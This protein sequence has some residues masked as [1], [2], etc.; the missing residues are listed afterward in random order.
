MRF[1]MKRQPE[2]YRQIKED[3]LKRKSALQDELQPDQDIAEHTGDSVDQAAKGTIDQITQ[4]LR[5]LF[6]QEIERINHALRQIERG[7]FGTCEECEGEISLPRLQ[8]LPY[9]TCCINCQREVEKR[10][11]RNISNNRLTFNLS[12][13]AD[14]NESDLPSAKSAEQ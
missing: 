14:P 5:G 2:I 9:A 12:D 4:D 11:P 10:Q 6:A 1:S 8:A 3:L 13:E 7:S